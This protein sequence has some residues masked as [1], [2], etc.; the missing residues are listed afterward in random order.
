MEL[1]YLVDG[2]YRE[3][4]F[5]R[6]PERIQEWIRDGPPRSPFFR[7]FNRSERD[8]LQVATLRCVAC[9]FLE[10]YAPDAEHTCR[11]CGYDRQGLAPDA[12]CPECGKSLA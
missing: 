12:P 9:G 8:R 4:F 1:G 3:G 2:L 5:G 7:T 10:L 6:G 11:H